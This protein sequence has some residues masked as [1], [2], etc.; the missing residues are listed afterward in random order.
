MDDLEQNPY[1]NYK[2]P[3]KVIVVGDSAVGKTTLINR[4]EKND[5]FEHIESTVGVL[6]AKI[7]YNFNDRVIE[8]QIYDTAGQE[9]YQSIAKFYLKNA[10]V[11][12]ICFDPMKDNWAD[13][14]KRWQNIVINESSETNFVI[15]AMK[16]DLWQNSLKIKPII[17]TV[18]KICGIDEV[19]CVSSLTGQNVDKLL[20]YMAHKCEDS[21]IH[22]SWSE[23]L[24]IDDKEKNTSCSCF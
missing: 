5:F 9:K 20:Y 21:D 11:S 14:I 3:Y 15:V 18:Q 4:I 19:F 23:S 6:S 2:A 13:S 24:V 17:S 22:S 16:Y 1:Q 12:L 8:F 7:M 10:K